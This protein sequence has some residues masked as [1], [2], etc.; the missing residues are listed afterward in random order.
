MFSLFLVIFQQLTTV[1]ASMR[2][3]YFDVLD[4]FAR[5]VVEYNDNLKGAVLDQF[6]G[7]KRLVEVDNRFAYVRLAS[8][9]NDLGFDCGRS[10]GGFLFS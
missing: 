5:N 4:R 8:L 9:E 6:S 2:Y 1:E 10:V 7:Q 3:V